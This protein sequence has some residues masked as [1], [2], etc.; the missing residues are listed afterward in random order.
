MCIIPRSVKGI[1][2]FS[3][4]LLVF[5]AIFAAGTVTAAPKSYPMVC[6]AG[7]GMTATHSNRNIPSPTRLMYSL[8]VNFQRSTS[9]AS[10]S[11]PGPGQCAWLDRPVRGDE[12]T[13]LVLTVPDFHNTYSNVVFRQGD[14]HAGLRTDAGG[15]FKYLVNA[16]MNGEVF[17]VHARQ[18]AFERT[19]VLLVTRTG[20]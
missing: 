7:G 20:P 10:T 11:Q 18:E 12:P 17:Y 4:T 13:S 19:R 15:G 5:A 6:R 14:N 16:I 3:T 2:M 9:G 8:R 1:M